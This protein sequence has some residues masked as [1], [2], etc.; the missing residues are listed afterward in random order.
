MPLFGPPA[1]VRPYFGYRN[2]TRLVLS[3]RAL[4]GAHPNWDGKSSTFAKLKTM[5]SHFASREVPDLSVTIETGAG[6]RQTQRAVAT[7][8]HEGFIHFDLPLGHDCPLPERSSWETVVLR[9][10]SRD[11]AQEETGY[12]LAPGRDQRLGVISDIDDT[13]LE[14][15]A[16]DLR[17][18]WRRV[19]AQ[20]PGDRLPVP[21]AAQFYARLGGGSAGARMP[22]THRPFFYVSS[23]PWNLFDYLIAFQTAHGLP[24]GPMLLRDW[25]FN[26]ATLGASGHGAHKTAA[27][28]S[29]LDFYGNTRFALIGDSTQADAIAYADA[30]AAH[31]DR[32]AGVLI[33]KAPGAPIDATE[34]AALDAIEAAGVPLWLGDRFDVRDDFLATLGLDDHD[35]RQIASGAPEAC[36]A[37]APVHAKDA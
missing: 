36:P 7:T 37:S 11:G 28:G 30:V 32:V 5:L 22:A 10:Q 4:R 16:H 29:I 9:W 23:S 1:R 19:L 2:Q 12:V 13:I 14:T 35:T 6:E 34:M 33:R 26:R 24:H 17:R 31:P 18:N 20:M 25:G 3:L 15:G 8:D 21:G 27:I